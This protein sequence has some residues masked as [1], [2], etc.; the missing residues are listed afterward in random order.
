VAR[1]RVRTH[2]TSLNIPVDLLQKAKAQ[3]GTT[4]PTEAVTAAL[5]EFVARRQIEAL[6]AME[7]PDLTLE[8]VQQM[9]QPRSFPDAEAQFEDSDGRAC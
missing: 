1:N 2:R 3:L 6:L 9:R 4:S 7:L 5:E 8:A